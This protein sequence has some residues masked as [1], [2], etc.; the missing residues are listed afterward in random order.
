MLG[1]VDGEGDRTTSRGFRLLIVEDDPNSR[2]ALCALM[3]R[4]GYDCRVA[5]NGKEALETVADFG[6]QVILMDLGLPVLDGLEAT[7]RLKSDARTRDIPVLAV[8]GNDT[9]DDLGDA[10]RAGFDDFL[11]KPII[12]HK[13]L[14]SLNRQLRA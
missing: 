2:W 1:L 11:T 7:R 13:L 4:M 12:F 6:P 10:R 9:A 14:D 5:S 8:T 3:S